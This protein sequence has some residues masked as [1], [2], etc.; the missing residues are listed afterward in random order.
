MLRRKRRR[1]GFLLMKRFLHLSVSYGIKCPEELEN[2]L[3]TFQMDVLENVLTD[4]NVGAKREQLK[5][6]IMQR[7]IDDFRYFKLAYLKS[8]E[9]EDV[10]KM[11]SCKNCKITLSKSE[12]IK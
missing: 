2:S 11:L 7:Q 6:S 10:L 12:E 9:Q 3:I 4:I 5:S 8:K 1:L